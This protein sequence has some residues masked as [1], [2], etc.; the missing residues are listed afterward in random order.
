LT[1][2]AIVLSPLTLPSAEQMAYSRDI[3]DDYLIAQAMLHDVDIIVSGDKD[4]LDLIAV[5]S[6]QIL[7]PAQFWAHIADIP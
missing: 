6:V 2:A 5:Q 3:N 1:L 7:S 4:L